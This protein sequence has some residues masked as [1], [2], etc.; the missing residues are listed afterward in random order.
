MLELAGVAGI[1]LEWFRSFLPGRYQLVMLGEKG[2]RGSPRM[3]EP[4][5]CHSFPGSCLVGLRRQLAT[6]RP[7]SDLNDCEEDYE[8]GSQIG[9]AHICYFCFVRVTVQI[10]IETEKV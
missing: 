3:E 7:G 10:R 1:A 9:V 5:R 8:G 6:W 2:H 4:R